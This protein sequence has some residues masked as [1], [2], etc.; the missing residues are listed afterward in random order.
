MNSQQ[1]VQRSLEIYALFWSNSKPSEDISYKLSTTGPGG[2]AKERWLVWEKWS[3]GGWETSPWWLV[4][5][6]RPH[7]RWPYP[8]RL[9]HWGL[10]GYRERNA[11]RL[12]EP[13]LPQPHLST[14]GPPVP[15]LCPA[16]APPQGRISSQA[17][18][19]GR[20]NRVWAADPFPCQFFSD[21]STGREDAVVHRQTGVAALPKDQGWLWLPAWPL[22]A[23]H[24]TGAQKAWL[25]NLAPCPRLLCHSPLMLTLGK[26]TEHHLCAHEP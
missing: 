16:H 25:S 17:T 13:I 3:Q 26:G 1:Q 5:Q 24:L 4:P 6:G 23:S 2:Q 12:Q 11:R 15:T 20:K 9:S 10:R 8:Q 14:E 22:P 7:P 19:F 18:G 21:L